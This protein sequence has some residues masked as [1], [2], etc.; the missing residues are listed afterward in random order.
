MIL[1]MYY[2]CVVIY[3]NKLTVFE[4]FDFWFLHGDRDL[5]DVLVV[6]DEHDDLTSLIFDRRH[7]TTAHELRACK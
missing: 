3:N 6:D 2:Y 4:V 5:G 1:V 7:Q